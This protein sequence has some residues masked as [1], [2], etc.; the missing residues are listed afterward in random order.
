MIWAKAFSLVCTIYTPNP[1]KGLKRFD[2][3]RCKFVSIFYL[4]TRTLMQQLLSVL[5]PL[6]GFAWFTPLN[7]LKGLDSPITVT[8]N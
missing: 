1:L 2:I 6:Q 3:G 5:K 8:V 7:P 4:S